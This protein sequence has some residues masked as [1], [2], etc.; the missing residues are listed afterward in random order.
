MYRTYSN[1]YLFNP[2]SDLAIGNASPNWQP[3]K[4]LIKMETD[5]ATLPMFLANADDVVL[6][7]HLPT[8]KYLESIAKLG[9]DL[10]EFMKIEKALHTETSPFK[11]INA[12][13]PWGWSPA[14][15][16]LLAPLKSKC[17]PAFQKSPVFSWSAGMRDL[18]SKKFAL[19]IQQQLIRE[20]PDTAFILKELCGQV[21]YEQ[22][23][24][25]ALI[26]RWGNLMI[27]APWSSSGRGLQPITKTPVHPKVWEKIL[28]IINDQGYAIAEPFLDKQLDIAFQ[29]ELRNGKISYLGIS[30]F[31]TDKKG[32][33]TGNRLNGLP[34]EMD[35]A[36]KTFVERLPGKIIDP[37]IQ[38]LEKS[39]LA[40]GYEG[41]FGVDVLVYKTTD[42]QLAVNPCLEINLRQNMGLLALQ[43]EKLLL[44]SQKALYQTWYGGGSSFCNFQSEMRKK[45]PPVIKNNKI[46]SG[47]FPLTDATSESKFGAYILAP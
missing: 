45:Y 47:F 38:V 25:E 44:P 18:Y 37:L 28:G 2:T 22:Q 32:Q 43:L 31:M 12:L 20:F 6:V 24:I 13:K 26:S 29:F 42:G 39:E 40:T 34:N 3:N 4:L 10:P 46:A 33:Y 7:E 41:N 30:N 23:Q 11:N 19:G 14:V 17:S 5:L 21:C 1:L 36:L 8:Q 9:L 27:K 35:S 16:K 15:H